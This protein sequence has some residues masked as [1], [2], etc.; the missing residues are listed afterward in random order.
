[1]IKTLDPVPDLSLYWSS[2]YDRTSLA[3]G[4]SQESTAWLLIRT[5][6]LLL[7]QASHSLMQSLPAIV[8]GRSFAVFYVRHMSCGRKKTQVRQD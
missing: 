8:A 5:Q 4:A 7:S 3:A 1:M 6:E 2:V